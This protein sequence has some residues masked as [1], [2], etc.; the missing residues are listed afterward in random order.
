[1]KNKKL[2]VDNENS[3]MQY[4]LLLVY[5]NILVLTQEEAR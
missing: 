4:I 5:K 3:P 2:S 1:M